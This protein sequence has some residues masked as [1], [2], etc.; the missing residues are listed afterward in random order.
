MPRQ[1]S[2]QLEAEGELEGAVFPLARRSRRSALACTA[3]RLCRAAGTSC[4]TSPGQQRFPLD[5]RG[6]TES[7]HQCGN[8]RE[9]VRQGTRALL[10]AG[11]RHSD[12]DGQA[13]ERS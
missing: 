2:G 12:G 3:P 8:Y 7:R 13:A 4:Y 5:P 9:L 6:P 10:N 1:C 11:R